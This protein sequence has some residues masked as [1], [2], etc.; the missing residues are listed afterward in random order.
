MKR[1]KGLIIMLCVLCVLLAVYFALYSWNSRQK[2]KEKARE[3]AG[4]I[5]VT[6]T[7]AAE[8]TAFSY[9][10]GNGHLSFERRDGQWYY[11]EDEDFPL[12]QSVPE[13]IAGEMGQITADRELKDGDDPA[14]YGLDEPQYTMEYTDTSGDTITVELGDLTGDYYYARVSGSDSIYTVPSSLTEDLNYTLDD[15]AVLDDYPAIGSGNL[16]RESITQN[17][18]TTTYDSEN[19]DQAEDIAAVAGGLGAVT[20]SRA[21]D[22]SVEDKDLEGYGLDETSRITVEAVYT[23]NGEEKTLTLYIGDEDEDGNRYVMIND[24][25]IVYLISDEICRNILNC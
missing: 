12:D 8:I 2:E 25:R 19:E 11:T 3:E 22:Y 13:Q 7:D 20:L 14:D 18:E 16:V 24:S 23:E 17:G 1:R 15:M 6:D 9:N 21:A 10:M 4:I 5:H